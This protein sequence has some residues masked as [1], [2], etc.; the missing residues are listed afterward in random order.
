[1]MVTD[2]RDDRIAEL[3]AQ[4]VWLK[5]QLA[6]R[7]G[8]LEEQRRQLAIVTARV[9]A[10]EELSRRS[11]RN[12]SQPP[13]GDGPAVA[14]RQKKRRTGRR[15]GAQKGH[16]K[17]ER[18]F[19]PLAEVDKQV[20]VKAEHCGGCGAK[21]EGDDPAP[22][23]HQVVELPRVKPLVTDFEIHTLGCARCG[24]STT[25]PLPAGV[26]TRAFGPSVDAT[27]GV[28]LGAYRLSKRAVPLLMKDL[29][30]L[31]LSVGAVIECQRAAST[32]LAE[33][34]AEATAHILHEPVKNADETGWRE[35]RKRAWLWVAVTSWVTVFM[36]HGRRSTDAARQLLG[37][38]K[39]ILGTDR[40]GAYTFWPVTSR[41]FC[42]AH[43]T[44]DFTAIAERGADSERIGTSLLAEVER[45]FTWW[46]RVRGGTLAHSSFRVYMRTVR[47]R[48]ETLLAEGAGLAHSKTAK[49]CAKVLSL[50]DALWTF[51]YHEGVE[52][53]NNAAERALR[54]AVL[55]RKQ[56]FGTHCSEGSRFV[57]RILTTHATLRQQKRNVLDFVRDACQA[58]L[59][60][61][62]G[63]SLLPS[64]HG[65]VPT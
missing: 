56:S 50:A 12:S 46:H 30:G 22:R 25:P 4:V 16:K 38:T 9:E 3:E 1:M 33:P 59:E 13:S 5:A 27:V 23:H 35:A 54:H 45:M 28:L 63:P 55:W 19:V 21:L 42:W 64:S 6:E 49:T 18:A 62:A 7:D 60:S 44:R 31:S 14:P 57:E 36:I 51:V 52:P 39:G 15:P 26:P 8:I 40:H 32:A 29:F 17:F 47:H 11:S 43:L 24:V 37:D 61:R 10:S 2:W 34:V 41:Q 65:I 53:T 48:V 20:V 58:I